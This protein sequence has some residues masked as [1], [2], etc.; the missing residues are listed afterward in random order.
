MVYIYRSFDS[1]TYESSEPEDCAQI[2]QYIEEK[3]KNVAE[4]SQESKTED[5]K[6]TE[7][8]YIDVPIGRRAFRMRNYGK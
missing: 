4:K 2:I 5:A 8:I 7:P 3:T 1:W 6:T